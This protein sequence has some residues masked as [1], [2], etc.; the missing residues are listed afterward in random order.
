MTERTQRLRE[1]LIAKTP[2]ICLDRALLMT[3]AYRDTE[4][5]PFVMRRAKAF[6]RILGGMT[7]CIRPDEPIVGN[8]ASELRA[9]P[10]FPEFSI[11]WIEKEIDEFP[12]RPFDLFLV[13]QGAKEKL[14]EAFDYWKGK[15]HSDR[16]VYLTSMMLPDEFKKAWQRETF[17][18]NQVICNQVRRDSGD[19]H[20]IVNYEKVIRRGLN[21]IIREAQEALERLN[22]REPESIEKK[23]F[24]EAAI[25]TLKAAGAFARRY[26]MLA[27]ELTKKERDAARRAELATIAGVCE[28]VPAHP[29][30]NFWEALQAYWFTHLLLQI[31]SNG[32]SVSFGRFDQILNPYF[33]KDAREGKITRE[34]ALELIECFFV[35]ASELNKV[36]PWNETRFKG[37]Y[38]M[39]QALTIGGQTRDGLDATNELTRLVLEATANMRL[40]QPTVALRIHSKTPE[41]LLVEA[42][43]AMVRHGGGLPSFFNDEVLIPALQNTGVGL[44]D[45]RDYAIMGCAEAVIP[46][47]SLST[48]GGGCYINLLKLLELALNNGVNPS[49]DLQLCPGSGDPTTFK[50]IND[51]MNAYREQLEY[52]MQLVPVLDSTIAA[53]DAAL[54]PTPFTSSLIDYRLEI[55]KDALAGQG[56]NYAHTILQGHGIVNVGNALAAL[57]KLVFEEGVLSLIEVKRALET[58]F[59]GLKG[60]ETRQLLLNKAPKYGNDDDYADFIVKEVALMFYREA[61][62]YVPPRG[63]VYGPSFQSLTANVP[64]G[65]M[66]GATPDGR[67]AGEPLADNV[68]PHP[69]TDVSG[70]TAVVKSV[71][72]LDHALFVNGNILNLKFHPLMV[73]DADGIRNLAALIKTFFDLKGYQVQFNIFSVEQLREA[74]KHPERYR[75]LIVKVAG[76]SAQF[77]S[78]DKKLQDQIIARTEHLL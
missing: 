60:E 51:V 72:K 77:I 78:L 58:N 66:V 5:L 75:D 64:Q 24:L 32:H 73:K 19:G 56:P 18:I 65:E 70:P 11:D 41:E 8:Q 20:V 74:Q 7:I 61:K 48:N 6:E 9:A 12:Q 57:K 4:V 17:R 71:A 76:Y 21:G 68:S 23:L 14:R 39:F 47:K 53:T 63:G 25:V 27:K 59:E 15:T 55:G 49:N 31:E 28:R 45:A 43:E 40:P 50:S 69:G 44:E 46:G 3:E 26:A 2:S 22:P 54:N 34:K 29:A 38:P 1:N 35:K 52:Y 36:R 37:G 33:K 30:R 10:L 67:R 13:P 62:K 16:V 42:C